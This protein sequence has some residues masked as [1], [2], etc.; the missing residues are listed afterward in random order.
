MSRTGTCAGIAVAV[1]SFVTPV[2]ADSLFF[3]KVAVKTASEVTCLGFASDTARGLGFRN[4]HKSGSEVAGEKNGAYIAITC[5][6]RGN[7]PAIAVVMSVAPDFNVAKQAGQMV[8]NKI[9]GIQ[10]ID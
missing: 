6:G 9:K 8:A 1:I 2:M 10:N 5:I 7:Q 3:D 4:V